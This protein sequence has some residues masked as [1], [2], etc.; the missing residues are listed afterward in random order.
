MKRINFSII[1]FGNIA[2]LSEESVKKTDYEIIKDFNNFLKN[3]I[4]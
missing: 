3:N 1:G 2:G 4:I